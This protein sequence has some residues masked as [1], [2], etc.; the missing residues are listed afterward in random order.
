MV[1]CSSGRPACACRR[2]AGRDAGLSVKVALVLVE[3][4][5]HRDE[6]GTHRDKER[7]IDVVEDGCS[8]RRSAVMHCES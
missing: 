3:V 5:A 1:Y 7:G 4:A 8:V 6:G 2:A